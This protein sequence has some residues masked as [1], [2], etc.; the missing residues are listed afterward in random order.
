MLVAARKKYQRGS[1]DYERF[2]SFVDASGGPDACHLWQGHRQQNGYG[3]FPVN[4]VPTIA[5]RWILGYLRGRP[6]RR[7]EM[8]CHHCDNPPC[9][10][11][12][13]LYVGDNAQ[14]MKDA[15]A[16]GTHNM[17][18]KTHCPQG[19]PYDEANTRHEAGRRRCVT[20]I[21]TRARRGP[22]TH[23]RNGHAYDAA[24]TMFEPSGKRR[25]RM[26]KR[27]NQKKHYH[28]K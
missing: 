23:C 7:D 1:T 24:N 2:A 12:K 27:I 9:V 4:R 25:C 5:S 6:L 22:R 14:N 20:C 8:A 15:V 3:K 11:P 18:R 26:C 17:V 10:N 19:H 16:R 21:R 28:N 13:H